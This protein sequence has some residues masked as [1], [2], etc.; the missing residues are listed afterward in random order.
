MRN[1]LLKHMACLAGFLILLAPLLTLPL[2][3]QAETSMG[4]PETQEVYGGRIQWIEVI[5]ITEDQS[6]AFISTESANSIFYAD[7]DHSGAE[8]SF[9]TFQVV[10]D[11]DDEA[12]FGD[13]FQRFT[14]DEASGWLFLAVTQ[15]DTHDYETG[16]YRCNTEADSLVLVQTGNVNGLLA[17]DGYLFFVE[18]NGNLHFGTV[19]ET[20]GAFTADD[21]SPLEIAGMPSPSI[22]HNPD[23]GCLYLLSDDKGEVP[24]ALYKSSDAYNEFDGDT[25]FAELDLPEGDGTWSVLGCALDGRIL[26]NGS[27]GYAY[28]DDDGD[29][30]ELVTIQYGGDQPPGAQGPNFE[31]VGDA[32]DYVIYTGTSVSDDRGESW[33]SIPRDDGSF[34]THPNTGCIKSDSNDPLVIY[35]TTD[36]GIGASTDG[37]TSIFEIDD[38]VD[39]VQI[40]DFVL[41]GSSGTGWAVSKSGIRMVSDYDTE[42]PTWSNAMFAMG[43]GSPYYAVDIDLSDENGETAYVGNV[44]VYKTT[45]GGE[46]W[47]RLRGN[48]GET[49]EDAYCVPYSMTDHYQ[50]TTVR[51]DP[52]DNDGRLFVGYDIDRS[53]YN[54]E[55]IVGDTDGDSWSQIPIL[56]ERPDPDTGYTGDVDVK[57][58]LVTQEDDEIV[59]YVAVGYD[60]DNSDGGSGVYRITGDVNSGWNVEQDLGDEVTINELAIDSEGT[61]YASGTS[62]SG[63]G[64][65]YLPVVYEKAS[66]EEWTAMTTDGLLES[67]NSS[68]GCVTVGIDPEDGDAEIPYVAYERF[69]YYLPDGADEW[70]QGYEYP[71]G[72]RINVIVGTTP[73]AGI[74]A[75]IASPAE[76]E[77][78]STVYVGTG[79][80]LYGHNITASIVDNDDSNSEGGGGLPLAAI[81]GGAVGAAALLGGGTFLLI[82]RRSAASV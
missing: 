41:D 78:T 8:P 54:G 12:G 55:I 68:Q 24:G 62:Y 82:R 28:S 30:W 48:P 79:T 50:I 18:G 25:S 57:D 80:G 15:S 51:F 36:Q 1:G 23:N 81:I 40:N 38:G 33:D 13:C 69:V 43:D 7:V 3:T 17:Y 5:A 75:N 22:V 72:T 56:S 37:A 66:G 60:P 4:G 19:D 11:L 53:E 77:T 9:G 49:N 76:E 26:L 73:A 58:I 35:L 32:S 29:N 71:A 14:V 27:Q 20:S 2:A 61:L 65:Q 39:A 47:E 44:R 74:A 70:T 59:I 64:N 52:Y 31:C 63:T 34:E 67:C 6:R 16:L 46:N 42:E 21:E 10:P 45:D